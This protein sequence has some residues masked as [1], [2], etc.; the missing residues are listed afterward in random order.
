MK[1]FLP[2][3]VHPPITQN[4]DPRAYV[5]L[6]S[7]KKKGDVDF[8]MSRGELVR[9]DVNP[10]KWLKGERNSATK[11]MNWGS[12]LD[13]M[14]LTPHRF[15]DLY[16]VCPETYT[17]DAGEEKPWNWNANKCK[18]WRKDREEEGKEVIKLEEMEEAR[19]A[20]SRLMEDPIISK[21]FGESEVQVQ[22]MVEYHD[23]DT[24]LVIQIKTLLD[25]V[26]NKGTEWGEFLCDLKSTNDAAIYEWEKTVFYQHYAEQAALYTDAF[27]AVTSENRSGFLHIVQESEQ[28]YAVARRMLSVE[29]MQLGRDKYLSALKRYCRCLAEQKFP[30]YD[31]DNSDSSNPIIDG[32]RLTNPSSWMV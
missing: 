21:L 14:W 6:G 19:I 5:A 28:P 25:L 16:A 8:I 10:W 22:C 23:K 11:A 27:N 12:A 7:D 13:C 4:A 30:G 2:S 3:S 32:W 18:E 1:Q 17:N 29:F 24:K 15:K 26:P 31:D 9:F 20:K